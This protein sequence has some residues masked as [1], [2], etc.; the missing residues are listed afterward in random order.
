MNSL[1]WL[2]YFI[3]VSTNATGVLGALAFFSF[4]TFIAIG[5]FYI[6]MIM[7]GH[8]KEE[9]VKLKSILKKCLII[10]S[11]GLFLH[12]VFPNRQTMI[13]IASSEI[14]DRVLQS[15]KTGEV[16]NKIID[17]SINLLNAYIEEEVKK[18]VKKDPENK[19]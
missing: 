12:T 3:G 10:F 2:I 19:K 13:L 17:P 7:N 1:S 6:P 4:L 11:I 9:C 15:Q 18:I 8:H 5:V 14:G 16:L